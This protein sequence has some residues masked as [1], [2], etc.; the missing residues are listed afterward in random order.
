MSQSNS[1]PSLELRRQGHSLALVLE[2]GKGGKGR[3]TGNSAA[4]AAANSLD[5]LDAGPRPDWA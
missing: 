2:G 1:V 4:G 3:R 5:R